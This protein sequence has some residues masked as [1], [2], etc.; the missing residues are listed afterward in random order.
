MQYAFLDKSSPLFVDDGPSIVENIEKIL[1][2]FRSKDFPRIFIKR[3]HRLNGVDIERERIDL[4]KENNLLVE[5]SKSIEI[6]EE[7]K[8]LSNE[9]VVIKKRYS[10]FFH[11]ELDLILRRMNVRTLILTGV[12]TPNCIR[13]TAIDAI[14][15]DYECIVVEDGTASKSSEIQRANL[16]DMGSMGIRITDTNNLISLLSE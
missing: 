8:P 11:T 10:S 14:S 5:G 2:F 16:T 9:I 6:I 3:V 15:L 13:A 12:Q 7:L 4:L 1:Q